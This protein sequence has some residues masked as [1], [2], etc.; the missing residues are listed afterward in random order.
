MDRTYRFFY[1]SST[2]VILALSAFATT[3]SGGALVVGQQA[4]MEGNV[5]SMDRNRLTYDGNAVIT[6]ADAGTVSAQLPAR[7]NL[8]KAPP[9]GDVQSLKQ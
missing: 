4:T 9:V 5:V 1:R 3:S 8:C 6:N 7:W 2:E